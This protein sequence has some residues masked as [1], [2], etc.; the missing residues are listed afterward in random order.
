MFILTVFIVALLKGAFSANETCIKEIRW[1]CK[2]HRMLPNEFPGTEN[3]LK[4]LV[5]SC[6]SDFEG[7]K[8]CLMERLNGCG[9]DNYDD[10]VI[11]SSDMSRLISTLTEICQ[12]D[13]ELHK[14]FVSMNNEKQVC[15]DY[16]NN[17]MDYLR[18][19]MK[20][21]LLQDD[22]DLVSKYHRCL[23]GYRVDTKA[24]SIAEQCPASIRIDII[25]LLNGLE[26]ATE[27]EIYVKRLITS[28]SFY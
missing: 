9:S 2:N 14:K 26:S 7:M 10:L 3:E 4:N 20:R 25:D 23:V 6:S 5:P 12:E 28:L 18:G 21:K 27:E 1:E 24:Y 15:R 13:T 19:P 17:A 11:A 8:R 16:T 22:T